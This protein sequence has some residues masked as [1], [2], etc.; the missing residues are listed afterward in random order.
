VAGT[1]RTDG[2]TVAAKLIAYGAEPGTA[3]EDGLR[4]LASWS[5]THDQDAGT[6]AINRVR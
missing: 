4:V 6:D 2:A 5:A 3:S 1:I